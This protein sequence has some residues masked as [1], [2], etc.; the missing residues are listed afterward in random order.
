MLNH[1]WLQTE[2]PAKSVDLLP[3][4]KAAFDAKKTCEF[5]AEM[6]LKTVRT[7]V[8]GM[9]AAHRLQDHK[10]GAQD[11]EKS[12]LAKD[13]AQYKDEA[14]KVSRVEGP[15]SFAGRRPGSLR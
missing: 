7:A 14:E 9:V 5:V 2:A 4:V 10:G 6:W 1:P 8:W 15:R 3:N 13:V 11:G 12:Q